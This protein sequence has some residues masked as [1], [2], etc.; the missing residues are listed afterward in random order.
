M[1]LHGVALVSKN[2]LFSGSDSGGELY[3]LVGICGLAAWRL[4]RGCV[5]SSVISSTGLVM[6]EIHCGLHES[7]PEIKSFSSYLE[8]VA[9]TGCIPELQAL[10][11]CYR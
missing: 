11:F 1:I 10:M 4:R 9:Q 8:H 5:T 3:Y 7:L 2:W 6:F